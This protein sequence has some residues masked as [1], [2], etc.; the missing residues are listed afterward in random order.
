MCGCVRACKVGEQ[1]SQQED[2]KLV[3]VHLKTCLKGVG[4]IGD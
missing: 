1:D 2:E 3:G 4:W